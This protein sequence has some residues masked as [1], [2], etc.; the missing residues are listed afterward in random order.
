MLID[1]VERT[2]RDNPGLTATQLA[3]IL[4][5]RHGYAERI[6]GAC[7]ALARLGRVE[8]R[9]RGGFGDPFRYY[10]S[11]VGGGPSAAG[12]RARIDAIEPDAPSPFGLDP[13]PPDQLSP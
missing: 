10:P 5:G 12:Y 9:G 2:I 3:R 13:T 1:D 8:R 7:H 11:Q 6:N 4:F